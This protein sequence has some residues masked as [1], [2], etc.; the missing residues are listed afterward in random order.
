MYYDVILIK[1]NHLLGYFYCC[2]LGDWEGIKG[3]LDEI[4]MQLHLNM[5]ESHSSLIISQ[6]VQHCTALSALHCNILQFYHQLKSSQMFL[7]LSL[8]STGWESNL[9]IMDSL[10]SPSSSP[11]TVK[12]LRRSFQVNPK[13]GVRPAREYCVLAQWDILNEDNLWQFV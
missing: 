10:A 1:T 3:L 7:S 2:H 8:S 5:V 13:L 11:Q 6:L 9:F 4:Q 12:C